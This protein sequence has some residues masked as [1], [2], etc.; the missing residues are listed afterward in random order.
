MGCCIPASRKRYVPSIVIDVFERS[1]RKGVAQ[2][3]YR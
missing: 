2:F 1:E 3:I